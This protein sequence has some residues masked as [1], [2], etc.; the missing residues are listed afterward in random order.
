MHTITPI[1][2]LT[3]AELRDLAT[4]AADRGDSLHECNPCVPGTTEYLN[5]E[6]DYI[7]RRLSFEIFD[8]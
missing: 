4:A 2:K 3:R 6:H 1:E 8:T 7:E 5:F